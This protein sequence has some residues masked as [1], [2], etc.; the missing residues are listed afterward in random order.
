MTNDEGSYRTRLA[1]SNP[2]SENR[3]SKETRI[4]KIASRRRFPFT[5]HSSRFTHHVSNFGF[6]LACR[7]DNWV[8]PTKPIIAQSNENLHSDPLSRRER[9]R[10]RGRGLTGSSNIP[11]RNP[12]SENCLASPVFR[13]RFTHHV[14][15]FG[16]RIFS[17]AWSLELGAW[18][19]LSS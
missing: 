13:S 12:K 19:T 2:K 18:F 16:F 14:S 1:N 5:F 4:S 15:N 6:S 11:F 10:V 7:S 17:G 3:N 9:E 8:R